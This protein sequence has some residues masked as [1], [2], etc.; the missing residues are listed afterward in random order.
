VSAGY[1]YDDIDRLLTAQHFGVAGNTENF[2]NMDDLGNRNGSVALWNGSSIF[3]SAYAENTTN[4][5]Y[6][7]IDSVSLSYDNAGSLTGDK[8]GYTYTYDYENRLI[9]ISKGIGGTTG[10]VAYSYDALGRRIKKDDL[11]T[12]ANTRM[13]YYNDKAQ[14]TQ[15]VDSSYTFKRWH[16]YDS[17]ID[18]IFVSGDGTN[19]E[20]F[21][22]DHLYSVAAVASSTASFAVTE[23]VEYSSYGDPKIFTAGADGTFYTADD[24]TSSASGFGNE[25]TFTGRRLDTLDSGNLRL[26]YYRNRYYSPEMGRFLQKDPKGIVPYGNLGN[27][28][29]T[30]IKQYDDGLNTYKYVTGNVVNFIDPYGLKCGECLPV[31]YEKPPQ[32]IAWGISSKL[33]RTPDT[34]TQHLD[35][36]SAFSNLTSVANAIQGVGG[37]FAQSVSDGILGIVDVTIGEVTGQLAGN[38]A[39]GLL[40]EIDN[41][42]QNH[43]VNGGWFYLWAKIETK[44]CKS[45]SIGVLWWK[46][47]G[48]EWDIKRKWHPCLT[49]SGINGRISTAFEFPEILYE[50]AFWTCTRA[51]YYNPEN[52]AGSVEEYKERYG[53]HYSV[54]P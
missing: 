29:L 48:G 6:N 39:S 44:K 9:Y 19:Y 25:Y 28:Y 37:G 26:M 22:R 15:E 3:N 21:F 43:I 47:C 50:E 18:E 36:L 4:N 33:S 12:T 7:T 32:I 31:G 40:Y 8:A 1:T 13:Y 34:L 52:P 46:K 17:Y 14:V 49:Q 23:R 35:K 45:C 41:R 2:T 51:A 5:Q 30:F 10:V 53:E 38:S 42:L 20:F 16:M 54:S 24:V 27:V 11:I